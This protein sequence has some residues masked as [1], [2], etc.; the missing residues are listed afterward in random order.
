M[1]GHENAR[2]SFLGQPRIN[3]PE[4]NRC[5]VGTILFDRPRQEP[6]LLPSFISVWARQSVGERRACAMGWGRSLSN[7]GPPDKDDAVPRVRK[8]AE[9]NARAAQSVRRTGC[10]EGPT[11]HFDRPPCRNPRPSPHWFPVGPG[12]G[13][14][15]GGGISASPSTSPRIHFGQRPTSAATASQCAQKAR[16]ATLL[17][18]P[19]R[20]WDPARSP[21]LDRGLTAPCPL[22]CPL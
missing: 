10:H 7:F 18:S 6:P 22:I 8:A 16:S 13:G 3:E 20:R 11:I 15:G 5:Q 1:F 9:G 19:V 21:R 12:D 17:C 4:Q 2:H 14:D